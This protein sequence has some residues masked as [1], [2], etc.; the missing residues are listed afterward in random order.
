MRN[1]IVLI[2]RQFLLNPYIDIPRT[3]QSILLECF[4]DRINGKIGRKKKRSIRNYHASLVIAVNIFVAIP[5]QDKIPAAAASTWRCIACRCTRNASA[6]NS[7][8]RRRTLFSTLSNPLFLQS[9]FLS[10]DKNLEGLGFHAILSTMHAAQ[11]FLPLHIEPDVAICIPLC[12]FFLPALILPLSSPRIKST[13]GRSLPLI[14][15]RSFINFFFS[16]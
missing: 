11:I 15:Y 13:S 5:L 9:P 8:S 14:P 4:I 3:S 2:C 10:W 7:N 6:E 16:L 12:L 1:F